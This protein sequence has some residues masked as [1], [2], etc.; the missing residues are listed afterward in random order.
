MS[1]EWAR[2]T[3]ESFVLSVKGMHTAVFAV[4]VQAIEQILLRLRLLA[5][6][7]AAVARLV[8]I[9]ARIWRMRRRGLWTWR[10]GGSGDWCGGRRFHTRV[11]RVAKALCRLLRLDIA[12][13]A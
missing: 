12:A 10:L 13:P 7:G 1:H 6:D 4:L 9:A 11:C 3:A 8:R 2:E 5:R